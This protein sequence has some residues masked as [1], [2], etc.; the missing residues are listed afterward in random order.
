MFDDDD[1]VEPQFEDLNEY[2]FEDG[3]EKPIC[4]SIL[5][6][7]FDENDKVTDCNIEKNVFLRGVA[8]KSLRVY[9]K[10][11]A[12]KM[13]LDREKPNICVLSI[14]NKWIKLLKP[15]KCYKEFVRSVLITVQ[16]LHYVRKRDQRGCLDHLWDHL[17]EVFCKYDSKPMED[18]LMKHYR[19]I[20]L[21]V[22]KDVTL[23]KSK[24]LRKLIEN[25][26]ER[27][28]KASDPEVQFIVDEQ[29]VRK[30]NGNHC[31]NEDNNGDTSDDDG[32]GSD[33]DDS[34]DDD[35]TDQICAICDDGG[36]LLR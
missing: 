16:M 14:E 21:F 33:D 19:L 24:I 22:E 11:I 9:K 3:K 35:G 2:Y 12:W 10:V 26:F 15:R 28:K 13:E 34:G 7:Q 27:S 4:F 25:G 8:D 32:G 5:P 18:D 20:K 30:N 29:N 36:E 31:H 1:G 6:F 17:D 23:M